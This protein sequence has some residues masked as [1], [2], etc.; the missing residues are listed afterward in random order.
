[1]KQIHLG[2]IGYGIQ[3]S[4]YVKILC[5]EKRCPDIQVTAVFEIDENKRKQGMIDHPELPFFDDFE[6]MAKSGLVENDQ[7]HLKVLTMEEEEF[8]IPANAFKKIPLFPK[9][10]KPMVSIFSMP[11]SWIALPARSYMMN[12]FS[13][14]EKTDSTACFYAMPSTCLRF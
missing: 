12:P 8:N 14:K 5:D 10:L 2:I 7:I 4:H 1:M 9:S 13:L 3:G 11:G 6:A